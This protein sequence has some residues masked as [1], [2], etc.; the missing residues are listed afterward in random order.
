MADHT[1]TKP[2]PL[3]PREKAILR[4]YFASGSR[5]CV[6]SRALGISRTRIY[7]VRQQPGAQAFLDTMEEGTTH[8]VIQA[9]AAQ[10]LA[11]TLRP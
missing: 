2:R 3:S 8:A 1:E 5:A 11:P 6:A 9:R 7:E 4:A 10:L